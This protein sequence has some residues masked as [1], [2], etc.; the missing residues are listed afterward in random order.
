MTPHPPKTDFLRNFYKVFATMGIVGQIVPFFWGWREAL[1][2]FL[3]MFIFGFL[4]LLWDLSLLLVL[5][6]D[7]PSP[8]LGYLLIFLRY[9]LLA[10]LFYAMMALFVVNWIWFAIGSGTLLPSLL[11]TA[12]FFDH[13]PRGT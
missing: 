13:R 10:G 9:G 2:Y 7:R 6:P 8:T 5:N 3:G 12:F 4:F 11:V 1:S